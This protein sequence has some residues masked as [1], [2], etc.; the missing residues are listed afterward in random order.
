[1]L[2]A[3]AQT[4]IS[5]PPAAADAT[6]RRRN[7]W[8][9]ATSS[10][11]SGRPFV[12]PSPLFGNPRLDPRILRASSRGG[13]D[14]MDNNESFRP[15]E[16]SI[17]SQQLLG[18]VRTNFLPLALV[19]GMSFGLMNPSL[20]CLAHKYGLSK[21]STFGIFLISGLT[22]RSGQINA[23]VEAW[24]TGLYGLVSILLLSPF[25][26]KLIL[27]LHLAPQEF[28]TGL[29]IFCCMPT[30]LSS[31]VA[32]T[33]L[34]GGNSALALA[35]TVISNLLGILIVP[36]SLSKFI[37]EGAG[38]C[39]PAEKLL[40][41]LIFSL[42]VPLIT[43]KVI[44]ESS[45]DVAGYA[46]RNR[47]IL[48]MISAILLSL[49]PWIQVSRSRSL[50]L[51]V[52]PAVFLVA[53]GI[54]VLLHLILLALNTLAIRS[55]SAA[56]GGRGAVFAKKENSRA[57]I[58]VAS[59]KTLP[60]MVAVVEQ[61]GGVLGEP[62]LLVLPCVATHINQIIIDSFLVNLWL[63]NDRMLNYSKEA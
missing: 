55:L 13:S 3:A 42:L 9:P 16:E 8:I 50:L 26:S 48:S 40:W 4:L 29:A 54:G 1:M 25:F 23:A 32:L 56:F 21:F 38:V 49:V 17:W 46:D 27:Q 35:V 60:V 22:L 33:Q 52:K 11:F 18:F 30:T 7:P 62:G 47:Q 15:K 37:G 51:M 45:K 6:L 14:Q 36:F 31:G 10:C 24:P 61:L 28:V 20:G 59:Q 57:V 41:S 19:S 2:A 43:G 12:V 58:L 34:L 53:V 44:R 5:R 63:R 39:I